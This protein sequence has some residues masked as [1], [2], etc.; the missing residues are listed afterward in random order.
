MLAYALAAV[1]LGAT[2]S[3]SWRAPALYEL[4]MVA[5]R[6]VAALLVTLAWVGA[7]KDEGRPSCHGR[8]RVGWGHPPS[9]SGSA[10]D[11]AENR[12][13]SRSTPLVN[14]HRAVASI[15]GGGHAIGLIGA[16]AAG[17]PW[18]DWYLARGLTCAEYAVCAVVM[19]VAL[20]RRRVRADA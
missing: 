6:W 17:N 9:P 8:P 13:D 14:G 3:A 4:A 10:H 20:L 7:E 19:A 18:R 16:W 11:I 15:L 12:K 1:T 5:T 2:W